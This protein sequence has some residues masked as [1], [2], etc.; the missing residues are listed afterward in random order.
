MYKV[1]V[2]NDNK[3]EN[4]FVFNGSP[5]GSNERSGGKDKDK[6]D[7]F[8]EADK[9]LIEKDKLPKSSI[10]ESPVQIHKDDSILQI[11]K[12]ILNEFGKESLITY[13]ELYLFAYNKTDLDLYRIFTETVSR[14]SNY[15]NRAKFTQ[16]LNILGLTV[17]AGSVKDKNTYDDLVKKMSKRGKTANMPISLGMLPANDHLFSPN[18]FD[19][20]EFSAK[21]V[22]NSENSLLM[23][24]GEI[25]DNNIYVCLADD[26]FACHES[27]DD[28]IAKTYYPFL[29]AKSIFDSASLSDKRDQLVTETAK[30][31]DPRHFKAYEIVDLFYD[32]LNEKGEREKILEKGTRNYRIAI[33]PHNQI[34]MPL[35]FLFKNIHASAKYKLMKLNPGMRRENLYR[36]YSNKIS[37]TGRKIPVLPKSVINS[38][39]KNIG[40]HKQISI[41]NKQGPDDKQD[42]TIDIEIDGTIILH[43]SMDKLADSAALAAHLKESANPILE[44]INA[45]LQNIGYKIPLITRLDA[46]EIEILDMDY[47]FSI[48]NVKI[49]VDAKTKAKKTDIDLEKIQGCLYAIFDIIEKDV[50]EG[51]KLRFKRVENYKDMDQQTLLM[52]ETY[53]KSGRDSDVIDVLMKNHAMTMEEA[54]ARIRLYKKDVEYLQVNKFNDGGNT[55]EKTIKVVENPGLPIEM[56]LDSV[57]KT[58]TFKTNEITNI[59]YLETLSAYFESMMRI[60][61][62]KSLIKKCG[63]SS[64]TEKPLKLVEEKP[65]EIRR[66]DAFN[67]SP[68][69]ESPRKFEEE[70][71]EDAEISPKTP[72]E[73]IAKIIKDKSEESDSSEFDMVGIEVEEDDD[74]DMVG[75]EVEEDGSNKGGSAPTKKKAKKSEEDEDEDEDEEEEEE[76]GDA[77]IA[78]NKDKAK[79]TNPFLQKLHEKEPDIFLNGKYGKYNIYSRTCQ[80]VHRQPVLITEEEKKHIDKTS[81]GS[82]LKAMKF[83]ST[84]ENQNYY[85]CPRFWCF[86]TNASM[87]ADQIKNKECGTDPEY[88]QEFNIP[89]E[90]LNAKGEYI[91]HYPGFKYKYRSKKTKYCMPCCG[92][93]EWEM[94]NK[95]ETTGKWKKTNYKL[96][97]GETINELGQLVLKDGK[98][99]ENWKEFPRNAQ[100][101]NMNDAE[102]MVS[103]KKVVN[104]KFIY[105]PRVLGE[106]PE[107]GR[108]GYVQDSVQHFMQIDYVK[109]KVTGDEAHLKDGVKTLLK[110]GVEQIKMENEKQEKVPHNSLLGCLADLYAYIKNKENE[111][112]EDENKEEKIH[113]PRVVDG[114]FGKILADAVNINDFVRYGNASF[115]AAFRPH[116]IEEGKE[117][118]IV[119]NEGEAWI[120]IK[121]IWKNKK[122]KE[123]GF[124]KTVKTMTVDPH[125]DDCAKYNGKEIDEIV[126][127]KMAAYEMYKIYL[128]NPAIE[129]ELEYIWDL[130]SIK[131]GLFKEGLNMVIMEIKNN[132]MTESIDVMCPTTT[133]NKTKFHID[134]PTTFLIKH[135]NNLFE[136]VYMYDTTAPKNPIKT[137]SNNEISPKNIK[138]LLMRMNTTLNENCRG[139]A[140]IMTTQP[141]SLSDLETELLEHLSTYDIKSQVANYQGKI[142]ALHVTNTETESDVYIPCKPTAPLDDYPIEMMSNHRLWSSYED[143]VKELEELG[144]TVDYCKPIMKIMDDMMI[145]GVLTKSNQMVPIN[146]PEEDFKGDKL[147]ILKNNSFTY[148]KTGNIG[149]TEYIDEIITKTKTGDVKRKEIMMNAV[150]ENEFFR[151]FRSTIKILLSEPKNHEI[152]FNLMRITHTGATQ[153]VATN[154]GTGTGTG[155][156]VMSYREKIKDAVEELMK[157]TQTA[158]VIEFAKF[159]Q[160]ALETIYASGKVMYECESQMSE[161]YNPGCKLLLPVKN[162]VN[163]DRDNRL[164]YYYRIADELIRHQNLKNFILYPNHFLS[165]GISD[166][167]VNADEIIVL[168]SSLQKEHEEFP[169]HGD[170]EIAAD[171]AMPEKT[172]K[173]L[174]TV[175]LNV[176][177]IDVKKNEIEGNANEYWRNKVFKGT[178]AGS[179]K[180]LTFPADIESSYEPL[181]I[182][183]FKEKKPPTK[184]TTEEMRAII[185]ESYRDLIST[186]KDKDNFNKIKK[187][188]KERQGKMELLKDVKTPEE[189]E[190]KIKENSKYFMT[191]LDIFVVAQKHNLPIVLFSNADK[192]LRDLG[193][194]E[195]WLILGLRNPVKAMDNKF[196][197]IRSHKSGPSGVPAHKMIEGR[198]EPNQ[199]NEHKP[200]IESA[201]RDPEHSENIMTIQQFL[202]L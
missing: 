157:L 171:M 99:D 16:L 195:K 140:S 149:D 11:K 181:I 116:A 40:K 167:K 26:V 170:G 94:H 175:E 17:D 9:R 109:A 178:A 137:F 134:K 122:T 4:I 100:E 12:K 37:K 48:G 68:T 142:I 150:A 33:K 133:Y 14:S 46:K 172:E 95:D 168:E 96:K 147:P 130:V 102:E 41:S 117:T 129:K 34:T 13:H 22:S 188:L 21:T 108:W 186:P 79:T 201:I 177:S 82:Y 194:N 15:L 24:Y 185:W 43:G 131:N 45:H 124:P 59:G 114:K 64:E 38:L 143:T 27:S 192:K 85:I 189:F 162:L 152:R 182:A 118:A 75:I 63:V 101:C 161:T 115:T 6:E 103:K 51:A 86:K 135:P 191:T 151:M 123:M 193:L 19:A 179:I 55:T 80:S 138:S 60:W 25:V 183:Y 30:I 111:N 199:L 145:V 2:L 32:T 81:P 128:E 61:Q 76:E 66:A 56:K 35:E 47:T 90:H 153:K 44:D 84:P 57:T 73:T 104:V 39:S 139:R 107:E 8:S 127:E 49:E 160:D 97:E 71:K 113:V 144:K 202:D 10:I 98:I 74:D 1:W 67:F 174:N 163:R 119:D 5:Q 20:V 29:T 58:L 190:I 105:D 198:F 65:I 23:N 92:T 78:K 120:K 53:K 28:F 156:I 88:W 54:M 136:P 18:P 7:P 184:P 169:I 50:F 52:T 164:L 83:G 121:S 125:D 72:I 126:L 141:L 70:E 112:K 165:M 166:Y 197:F 148:N 36:L 155:S 158:N 146:P 200:F 173:Y 69:D 196:H 3:V 91:P 159:K 42:V 89:K 106:I 180:E 154:A 31:M 93:S 110:Y 132:D 77:Y 62:D 87:T 187:I 176:D